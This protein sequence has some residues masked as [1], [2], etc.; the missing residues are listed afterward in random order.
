MKTRLFFFFLLLTQLFFAQNPWEILNPKPSSG[1]NK[2]V[3]FSGGTGYIINDSKELIASSNNGES[4][5]VK[6]TVASANAISFSSNIGYIVGDNGYVLKS[7]DAG[8]TWSI[9]NIGTSDNLNS[10]SVFAGKVIISSQT[11]LFISTDGANFISKIIDIPNAWVI[12]T[13]FTTASEGHL[14]STGKIFR[15]T[16]SGTTWTQTLSYNSTPNDLNLLYFK[17]QNEGYAH[18]GHSEFRKTID[19]GQTWTPVQGDWMYKINS[20]Y[21]TDQ[22][23]GF[24]VGVNRNIYKTVNNGVTWTR[25]DDGPFVYS[26]HDL[27]SV[28]FANQNVGFAVGEN[29]MI[30]KTNNGGT[31]WVKNSFTYDNINEIQKVEGAFYLQAQ[32]DLYKSTDKINWQKL[33]SPIVPGLYPYVVDF[34][35]V[36]A[37]VGYSLVG[38]AGSANLAKTVDGGQN[39]TV[40]PNTYGG[41]RQLQFLNENVGYR[42]DSRIYKTID[43]GI[44]WAEIPTIFVYNVYFVT[45]NV[46]F[47]IRDTK[48]HRSNDGGVTWT[49]ISGEEYVSSFQFLNTEEGFIIGNN[50]LLKTKDGGLTWEKIPMN[51][52]YQYLHFQSPNIGFLSGQYNDDHSYTDNGGAT[53]QSVSKPFPDIS[54]NVIDNQLYIGG[55]SGRL[56]AT[57]LSAS[58]SFLQTKSVNEITA[59]KADILAYGSSNSGHLEN[60]VFEY[61]TDY[62]FSNSISVSANPT[63]I[64]AGKNLNLIGTI[65]QL[66]ADTNYYVRT[67]GMNSGQ[68]FISDIIAF[69][70][71]PA[72]TQ[73]LTF[74]KTKSKSVVLNATIASNDDKGVQNVQIIYG[75]DANNLTNILEVS[76]NG[77]APNETET[78]ISLLDSLAANTSYFLK[79]KLTYNGVEKLSNLYTFK[80]L[81]GPSLYLNPYGRYSQDFSGYVQ[82]DENL[83]NIRFQ[84]GSQNFENSFVANPS[85][86][87]EG[88]AGYV[89]SVSTPIFDQNKTYYIRIKALHEN[90]TLLSNV[91]VYNPYSPIVLAKNNEELISENSARINGFINTNGYTAT[92]LKII[93]GLSPESLNS[94]LSLQPDTVTN[95]ETNPIS[96]EISGLDFNKIYY[97]RFVTQSNTGKLT[98]YSSD[99]YSFSLSQLNTKESSP[100]NGV[101]IYPNPV[102][103]YFKIESKEKIQSVQLFDLQGKLLKFFNLSGSSVEHSF[104][105]QNLNSGVYAV[106]IELASGQIVHKKIIKK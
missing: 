79:I 32:Y 68:L 99:L 64:E 29:G 72:F 62:S 61:S 76:P 98:D 20:M 18:F 7:I 28:F 80:T 67:K 41:D 46:A 63:T 75:T 1:Q 58:S 33:T 52:M 88:Q 83:T 70:T 51:K 14:F 34:E 71:K 97:Y 54:R 103:D 66:T 21:F 73:M 94:S 47:G 77:V 44:T 105:I 22:N 53:W 30:L 60:I 49:A 39:W 42:T 25:Y 17:N 104:E 50:A 5:T 43:G 19:G 36:T 90:K 74:T 89:S 84:Y 31:T 45:E 81:I 57:N 69:R 65:S 10:V 8:V 38:T 102:S 87:G 35:M 82:A 96:G 106:K 91:E 92:N 9:L 15:T 27:K 59:Q 85:S 55:M 12:K 48:L 23:T 13:V 16:D 100:L 24:A 101:L 86:F 4:W 2:A 37:N 26:E 93:Y 40:L 56:A 6:Q 3:V 95:Y 11:K 78:I